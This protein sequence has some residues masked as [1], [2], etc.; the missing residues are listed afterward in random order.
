MKKTI[1]LSLMLCLALALFGCGTDNDV[2]SPD[3]S[4][5]PVSDDDTQSTDDGAVLTEADL[6]EKFPEYY[7]LDSFKGIEVYAWKTENGEYRCGALTGTNRLKT[8]DELRALQENGATIGEMKA[9]LSSYELEKNSVSILP[10][11]IQS[12][13]IDEGVTETISELRALLFD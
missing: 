1:I 12:T 7:G 2:D 13:V 3:E 10:I 6:R 8:E 11:D 5:A 9:I 4:G